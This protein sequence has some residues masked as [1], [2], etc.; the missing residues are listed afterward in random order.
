VLGNLAINDLLFLSVREAG[1]LKIIAGSSNDPPVGNR[2]ERER[3]RERVTV[4]T[5]YTM[6]DDP[7]QRG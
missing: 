5:I 2:S 4:L 3:E 7:F 6:V 1:L